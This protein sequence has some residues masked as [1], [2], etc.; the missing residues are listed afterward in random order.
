MKKSDKEMIGCVLSEGNLLA[1]KQATF[2]EQYIIK[3]ND[4]LYG[5]LSEIM[6]FGDMVL[7]SPLKLEILSKMRSELSKVHKIKTQKNTPDLLVIVKFIVRTN[8]KNAHVYARV[9]DMAY[10]SNVI[11]EE[12]PEFIKKNGGIDRIRESNADLEAVNKRKD[13]D[14]KKLKFIKAL[15]DEKAK[16]PFTSFDISKEFQSRVHDSRGAS[17]FFYPICVQVMGGYKV[18][19]VIPMDYDFEDKILERVYIDL[20]SKSYCDDVEKSQIARAKEIISPEYQL[21]LKEERERIDADRR[22]KIQEENKLK[23][24]A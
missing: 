12:L 10:R 19:G 8:R 6:A 7:T 9:I 16:T 1:D 18:V 21:R 4:V 22:A 11:P 15:L 14:E 2:N 5:L 17:L 13:L 3:A 24:A 20:N 23:L